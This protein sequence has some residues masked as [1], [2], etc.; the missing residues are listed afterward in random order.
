MDIDKELVFEQVMSALEYKQKN[1]P[2]HNKAVSVGRMII[3]LYDLLASMMTR[4]Q[5]ID[6]LTT[7][8]YPVF[9]DGIPDEIT[10][11]EV[12]KL[13][14][15]SIRFNMMASLE[16]NTGVPISEKME[17]RLTLSSLLHYSPLSSDVMEKFF[18][19]NLVWFPF[20]RQ[21]S[22]L[23]LWNYVINQSTHTDFGA[24]PEL[25]MRSKMIA[26][27]KSI[28]GEGF[29]PSK[30]QTDLSSN[31]LIY[32]LKQAMFSSKSSPSALIKSLSKLTW[33]DADKLTCG[34]RKLLQSV[35]NGFEQAGEGEHFPE[36]ILEVMLS[37]VVDHLSPTS[38]KE[39]VSI[40]PLS[41]ELNKADTDPKYLMEYYKSLLIHA[42]SKQ[43]SYKDEL[44]DIFGTLIMHTNTTSGVLEYKFSEYLDCR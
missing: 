17:P 4:Q 42:K 15:E 23:D 16:E 22:K 44:L 7:A 41:L 31:E 12:V 18:T 19:A 20:D 32:M 39:I 25:R 37:I 28:G 6:A 8:V 2:P 13:G 36:D 21:I 27:I 38:H 9:V 3:E 5:I 30:N 14:R 10:F 29:L 35:I 11:D 33:F 43:G 24:Y 40:L 26:A 1:T 34:K